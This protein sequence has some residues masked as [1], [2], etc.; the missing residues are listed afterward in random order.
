MLV[1]S[2]C[3]LTDDRFDA[4]RADVL[5]RAKGAGV[6]GILSIASDRDDAKR[7]AD[8][9]T[10]GSR[11]EE[12]PSLWGTAGIHPHEAE[13]A[14]EGDLDA[15]RQHL[16]SE[17][18]LVAVGETGLDFFYDHSPRER[19]E[20]LFRGHLSMA[21]DL[22]LPVVTHSRSA[23]ELTGRILEEWGPEVRGVLHCFTGGP[24]LLETAVKV[25][26]MVSFTGIITFKK[27]DG[28]ELVRSVPRDRLM[29]ETDAPYLAPVPQRGRRNEPA[30][31]GRVAECLAE[32]RGEALE[33]VL[34]YSYRNACR[35][36]GLRQ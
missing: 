32:M 5:L 16:V 35:F 29:V 21:R 9:V 24:E 7:V 14:R 25:G 23:D 22:D 27:Y 8:L 11:R 30:F 4:D 34:E 20:E 10:E 26:W 36:F 3:H 15:I 33:E 1:D 28:A 12:W 2:H 13:A 6:E 31:V 17:P 19:Q 18:G